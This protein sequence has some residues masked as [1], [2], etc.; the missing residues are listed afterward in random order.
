MS[1]P[2][3]CTRCARQGFRLSRTLLWRRHNSTVVRVRHDR[4]FRVAVVGSGP[5]GFYAASRLLSKVNDA[6]VDMYERLPVPFGLVRYGVAPDHPEVKV[7]ESPNLLA[8]LLTDH[9]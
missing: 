1:L 9:K 3:L 8:R 4:S 5:A 2:Y 7:R 6:V